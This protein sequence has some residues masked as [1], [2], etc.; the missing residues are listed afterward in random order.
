MLLLPDTN[1]LDLAQTLC[2]GQC[3][4][5]EQHPDGTWCGVVE[6][7]AVCAAQLPPD[8]PENPGALVL[9]GLAGPAP[10]TEPDFWRG[11]F[12]LD[13][14]YPALLENFRGLS[15]SLVRCVENA[16]GIRVLRQPFFE[17]LVTFL[18]SQNNNIPRIK[19]ITA[20]LCEG[21]GEAL[22]PAIANSPNEANAPAVQGMQNAPAWHTFPTAQ[23]L[24][25]LREED[26]AFLRAGWRGGYILDA[27]RR[28]AAGEICEE[29]LRALPLA[30]AKARLMTIRG[31]GPKVADC[32]LLYGLG[33]WD[34][35]PIDVWIKRADAALFPA[36]VKDAA[37]YLNRRTGGHAGI[38]QQY[39]FAWARENL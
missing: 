2:C 27:A 5:W 9:Q 34:A 31:V 4:R 8:A 37:A 3:F 38:A 10:E 35:Y 16:P 23:R 21:L 6:G 30:E 25:A 17:T 11:Y 26:L 22:P 24:A 36:R 1:G 29:E 28:V 19:A 32:T 14:D 13:L 39:I 33:R 18:I 7:R 15:P 20:R 12:A